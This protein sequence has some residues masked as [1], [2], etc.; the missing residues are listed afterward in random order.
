MDVGIAMLKFANSDIGQFI[1]QITLAYTAFTLFDKAVQTATF[2]TIILSLK[3]LGLAFDSFAIA[4]TSGT[5][6]VAAFK[7]ALDTLKINPVVLALT[8][9][10]GAVTLAYK[11]YDHFNVTIDEHIDKINELQDEYNSAQ[12]EIESLE[13]QLKSVRTNRSNK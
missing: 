2:K 7:L 5:K 10:V 9:V 6:G 4:M 12:S 11:A 13:E 8:A 3:N 1:I